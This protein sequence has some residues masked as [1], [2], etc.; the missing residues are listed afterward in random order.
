MKLTRQDWRLLRIPIICLGLAIILMTL[1]VSYV[2]SRA[3]VAEQALQTK[4]SQLLQA[5]QRYQTSGQEKQV[6][7]Q[8]LPI[9]QQLIADGFIGEERRIEWV[10]SLRNI[11]QQDKLFTIN[12]SIGTQEDY[13]PSFALNT[14][15]FSLHR[16]VMKLELAMLHEGDIL[17]LLQSLDTQQTAPF[18]LRQCEIKRLGDIKTTTLT[19]NMQASCELDWLTIREPQVEGVS[20][21]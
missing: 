8:Y 2:E 9:Y 20:V 18:I 3:K 10:D 1:L 21:Q 5:R 6:I 12:Y 11:H 4:Q 7:A 17:N 19:A 14:G 15:T 16:S 13:K